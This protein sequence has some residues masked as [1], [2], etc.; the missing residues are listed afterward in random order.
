MDIV[1]EFINRVAYKFPKGY[2]DLNDPADKKLLESLMGLNEAEEDD[3]EKKTI[4]KADIIKAIED[5][6]YTDNQLARLDQLVT[7]V[8]YSDEIDNIASSKGLTSKEEA[9]LS[10]QLDNFKQ[11]KVYAEYIENPLSYTDFP[12]EGNAISVLKAK[13]FDEEFLK[14]MLGVDF[15]SGGRGVGPGEFYFIALTKDSKKATKGDLMTDEGEVEVKA[16]SAML[17][18]FGR[19]D[20]WSSSITFIKEWL[21]NNAPENSDDALKSFKAL[22]GKKGYN[23]LFRKIPTILDTLDQNEIEEF[24]KDFSKHIEDRYSQHISLDVDKY[25]DGSKFDAV[26]LEND[27]AKKLAQ[28]Y[29]AKEGVDNFLFLNKKTGR[30]VKYP[31]PELINTIGQNIVVTSMQ[32]MTTRLSLKK[33]VD[34]T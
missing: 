32:D 27:I 9:F 18:P 16:G 6:E 28:E 25:F 2:P 15:Q 1:T 31:T 20:S 24:A 19:T 30:Y 4:S 33:P 14:V 5:S 17:S 8:S 34:N 7:S 23:G 12:T 13:G 3:E 26:A 11:Y 29:V 10:K 22:S 21:E